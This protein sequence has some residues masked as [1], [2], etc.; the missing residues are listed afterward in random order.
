MS[1][2]HSIL[3]SMKI[4][5]LSLIDR[6]RARWVARWHTV[7]TLHQQTI[8][9]HSH[10][11]GVIAEDLLSRFAARNNKPLCYE[12]RYLVLKYAQVHDMPELLTGDPSSPFKHMT[13]QALPG[14]AEYM[15]ALE[16]ALV[17]ELVEIE[18]ASNRFPHLPFIMK[19]ADLL[20]AISFFRMAQGR[21]K[22]HNDVVR[23]KLNDLLQHTVSNAIDALPDCCWDFI[24]EVKDE[25]EKNAATG[26]MAFEGFNLNK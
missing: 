11:V 12:Q 8:A 26:T 13:K 18:Q 4:T 10:C 5:P 20:E 6:L 9:E 23:M 21:D 17:P 3:T 1:F 2:S 24:V 7:Q 16:H 25:I 22:E 14:F 15:E 19:A